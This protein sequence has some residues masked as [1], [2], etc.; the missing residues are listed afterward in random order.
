[1]RL[2]CLFGKHV[3]KDYGFRFG[4]RC[5]YC[6]KRKPFLGARKSEDFLRVDART[7]RLP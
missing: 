5:A 7:W 6:P 1:M 2:R 3:F 4:Y